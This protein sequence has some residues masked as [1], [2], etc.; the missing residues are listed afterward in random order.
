MKKISILLAG[1]LALGMWSCDESTNA[2]PQTN[3]QL[4]VMSADAVDIKGELPAKMDLSALNKAGETITVGRLVSCANFP[5]DYELK[6]YG[7]VGRTETFEKVGTFLLDMT[8]DSVLYTSPS[9]FDAAYTQAIGKGAK[10]KEVYFRIYAMAVNGTSEVRLGG[11][12]VYYTLQNS[13]VLPYDKHIVIEEMY[14]LLG[15]VNGWSVADA[16]LMNH[17]G[18]NPYDD[19]IFTHYF[20]ITVDAAKA[21]WWWKV[22]PISTIQTGDWVSGLNAQFGVAINGDHSLAGDLI[23]TT[24]NEETGDFV[25]PQAGNINE[26]G[27]YNLILDMENQTYDFAK[28]F[29]LMYVHGAYSLFNWND[30]VR[31]MSTDENVYFGL[32]TV[33][34]GI[35]L[36]GQPDYEGVIYGKGLGKEGLALDATGDISIKAADAG[37][38]MFVAKLKDLTLKKEKIT[39]LGLIGNH[40]GWGE[41]DNLTA[42]DLSCLTWTGTVALD[43]EFKIRMNDN[44]DFNLGGAMD[45]LVF[46][47]ANLSAPAGTYDVTL[48]LGTLPYSITLVK[49]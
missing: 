36:Y 26:T 12:D 4:P 13:S 8:E 5:A 37:F 45:C 22:V 34:G 31:L 16:I 24:L 23:P 21:G 7:Q 18:I 35:K 46:D 44:W 9:T 29:D 40:N 19:P 14:G 25:E 42:T 17:S 11:A 2:V 43:G 32:G 28:V 1:V 48:D 20:D 15:T 33:S 38:M 49:H 39:S 30:D 3:P 27:V 41:Q 47:G 6:L 10:E